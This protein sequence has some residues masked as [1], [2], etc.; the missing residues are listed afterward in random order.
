[1]IAFIALVTLIFPVAAM[2][3]RIKPSGVRRL[4]EWAAWKEAPFTLFGVAEFFGFMGMYVPFFYVNVYAVQN[5]I[6]SE[7]LAFYLLAILN[8]GSIFG[9]IIPNFLADKTGPFN[10]LIPCT[11]ICIVL[12][13]SWMRIE[14]TAGLIVFCVLYGFFSGTFVSLPPTTIVTLCPSLSVVGVRMGMNFALAAIGL[15]IGN[16][17]AGAI[18]RSG[19]GEAWHGLMGFCG[20]C[21]AL[22]A[23]SMVAARV[24]K[25]GFNVM[26]KA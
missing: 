5:E 15:L 8:A 22:A 17:I 7:N 21:V 19:S 13:F 3:M 6:M 2:R 23:L 10:M 14:S 18:L 9:R 4:V 1:M 26:A 11:V 16:P 20:A 25:V 24:S 12:A